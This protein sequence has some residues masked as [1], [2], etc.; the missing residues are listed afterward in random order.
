MEV[1]GKEKSKGNGN[2]GYF[3]KKRWVGKGETQGGG[4]EGS[5]QLGKM[6]REGR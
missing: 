5:G 6:N 1:K 2:L 4:S 3:R